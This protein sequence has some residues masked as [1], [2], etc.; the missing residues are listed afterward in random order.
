MPKVEL[1]SNFSFIVL[2]FILSLLTDNSE[3][4]LE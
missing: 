3:K 2:F 4:K 1:A